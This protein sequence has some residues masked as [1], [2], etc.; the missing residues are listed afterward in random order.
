MSLLEDYAEKYRSALLTRS[1][2]V[3][4]VTLHTDGQPLVWGEIPHRELPSLWTDIAEDSENDVMIL[5]GTGDRFCTKMDMASWIP[6][7]IT[8]ATGWDKI[9]H[10]GTRLLQRFLEIEIPV[11]S[12]INGPATIHPELPVLGDIVIA[13]SDAVLQDAAHYRR[14]GVPGDGSHVVWPY[15]LGLNRARYFLMMAQEL[16]A[17]EAQELGVVNEVVEPSHVLDRA[18]EIA[19]GLRQLPDLTRRYTRAAL[20]APLRKRLLE[21]L[22]YGLILEGAA[23]VAATQARSGP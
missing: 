17:A 10:E 22:S 6:S 13:S 2:G 5:S 9:H 3:L 1:D 16:S 8:T 4:E 14:G 15:L 20:L 11:I 19:A 21:E 23:V 7:G 18:R 12:A